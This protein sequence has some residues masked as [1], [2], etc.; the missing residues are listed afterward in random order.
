MKTFEDLANLHFKGLVG[1]GEN[2]EVGKATILAIRARSREE[3]MWVLPV[4]EKTAD[5]ERAH[6]AAVIVDKL[7]REGAT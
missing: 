1:L 2:I 5:R 6:D 7:I 4:G 3:T